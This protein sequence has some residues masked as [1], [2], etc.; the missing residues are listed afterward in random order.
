MTG[1]LVKM[2]EKPELENIQMSHCVTRRRQNA[3]ASVA[4]TQSRADPQKGWNIFTQPS[5]I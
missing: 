3:D 1:G 4:V 2:H 5:Y